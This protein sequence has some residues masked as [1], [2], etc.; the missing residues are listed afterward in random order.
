MSQF[1]AHNYI[2]AHNTHVYIYNMMNRFFFWKTEL[3]NKQYDQGFNEH[4]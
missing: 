3:Y 2:I 1:T 4:L